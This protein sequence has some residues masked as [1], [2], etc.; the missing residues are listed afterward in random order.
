[1][2]FYVFMGINVLLLDDR[3]TPSYESDELTNENV[4][5][6]LSCTSIGYIWVS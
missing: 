5:K 3:M 4:N 1:M 2:L 6:Y